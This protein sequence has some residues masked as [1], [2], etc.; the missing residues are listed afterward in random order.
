MDR[1]TPSVA[2]NPDLRHA[3]AEVFALK[4]ALLGIKHFLSSIGDTD[5]SSGDWTA[6]DQGHFS[7]A[8]ASAA[9]HTA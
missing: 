6:F 2:A 1:R 8:D 7:L 4:D 3:L 9:Y 5:K